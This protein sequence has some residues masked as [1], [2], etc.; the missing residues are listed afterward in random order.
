[1]KGVSKNLLDIIK[2]VQFLQSMKPYTMIA[3][4]FI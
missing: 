2:P 1:M 3:Q 4:Y